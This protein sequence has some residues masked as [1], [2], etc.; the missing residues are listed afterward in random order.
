MEPLEPPRIL[1]GGDAAARPDGLERALTRAGFRVSEGACGDPG[2]A[3]DAVL[4]TTRAVN[5]DGVSALLA[6]CS[7]IP[8]RIVLFAAADP[9]LPGTALAL[10]AEDAV[11][12]PVHLPELCARIHARIRDRR[13]HPRDARQALAAAAQ[14]LSSPASSWSGGGTTPGETLSLERKLSEEFERARRYSLS[15]SLVLLAIEALDGGGDHIAVELRRLLRLP[16]FVSRYRES[17]FAILLPETDGDGA[18]RSI[19]R[20]RDRLAALPPGAISAGIVSYPHPAAA[21]P[22][23]LFALVEAALARGRA[24]GGRIGVAE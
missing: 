7:P 10:G 9:D 1:L 2:P 22:D 19:A 20:M 16:D 21:Q 17:E 23:D 13:S 24:V 11:A 8:P 12:A 18:R 14:A 3:P 15:F 5:P 6:P 4:L